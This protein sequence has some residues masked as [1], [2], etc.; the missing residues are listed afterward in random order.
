MSMICQVEQQNSKCTD[1]ANQHGIWRVDFIIRLLDYHFRYRNQGQSGTNTSGNFK[2]NWSPR[3]IYAKGR[4]ICVTG[5]VQRHVI[6]HQN[7]RTM[8]NFVVTLSKEDEQH[9][10]FHVAWNDPELQTHVVILDKKTHRVRLCSCSPNWAWATALR[11]F[12]CPHS[13]A[14]LQFLIKKSSEKYI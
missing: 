11:I 12:R 4:G 6:I 10:C 2:K 8:S 5:H 1:M 14:I 13:I 9:L 3:V 7:S